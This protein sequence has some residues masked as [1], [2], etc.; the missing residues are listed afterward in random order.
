[1]EIKYKYGKVKFINAHGLKIQGEPPPRGGGAGGHRMFLLNFW[2]WVGS[3][4]GHFVEFQLVMKS[5]AI[6]VRSL[7][8]KLETFDD[9]T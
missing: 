7:C 3:G 2:G 6:G 5:N 1:M 9:V 4:E 8:R